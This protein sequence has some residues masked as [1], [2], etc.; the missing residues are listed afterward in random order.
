MRERVRVKE[1]ATRGSFVIS[2]C[3][4]IDGQLRTFNASAHS[5]THLEH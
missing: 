2:F 1:N 4:L 3:C 5:Y